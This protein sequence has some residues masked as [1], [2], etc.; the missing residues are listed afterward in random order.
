VA[1]L[2]VDVALAE[3]LPVRHQG[4]ALREDPGSDHL[5]SAEAPLDLRLQGVIPCLP[6]AG[7]G[8]R[9]RPILRE[10]PNA[11]AKVAPPPQPVA[12]PG[13]GSLYPAATTAGS[14]MLRESSEPSARLL[15]GSWLM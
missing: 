8:I 4:Q 1:V 6:D 3:D 5:Q 11:C 9:D 12:K 10:R 2:R 7:V 13:N 14:F 15:V